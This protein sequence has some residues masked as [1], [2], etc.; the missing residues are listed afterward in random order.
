MMACTWW[1]ELAE[2]DWALD[3]AGPEGDEAMAVSFMS[4]ADEDRSDG[5]PKFVLLAARRACVKLTNCTH[6][7][8]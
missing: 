4:I 2:A 7:R 1:L 3:G 8:S 6:A 5:T